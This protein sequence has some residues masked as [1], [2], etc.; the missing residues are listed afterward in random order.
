M[1]HL[2]T[3]SAYSHSIVSAMGHLQTFGEANRMSGIPSKVDMDKQV[4]MSAKGQK[5]TFCVANDVQRIAT[6][7]AAGQPQCS[8]PSNFWIELRSLTQGC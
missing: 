5:Q 4:V 8:V 6:A 7:T 3:S 1:P 2:L